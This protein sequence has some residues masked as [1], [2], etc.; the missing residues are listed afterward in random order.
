M[1]KAAAAERF[2]PERGHSLAV[3]V[4]QRIRASRLER[5]LSLAQVG[6]DDLSRSFLSL[7]EL[8]HSR[9]SLRALAIVAERLDLP[10]S[11]FLQGAS[12]S[13]AEIAEL[14][15]DRAEIALGQQQPEQALHT[16]EL[17]EVPDSLR[18]RS[19]LVRGRALTDAGRP[20]DAVPELR[21]ALG[22]AEKRDDAFLHAH[23]LYHLG[24]ALY[25]AGNFDEAAVYL[26]RALREAVETIDDSIL[27]GKAT[28]LLGHILFVEDDMDGALEQYARARELFDSFGDLD[29]LGSVYSGLSLT[30]EHK[31]DMPN[32]LRYAKLSLRTFDAKQDVRRAAGELNNLAMKYKELDDISNAL[33]CAREAVQRAGEVKA[34]DV[35]AIAHG[36]LASIHLQREEIQEA[37]VEAELADRLAAD[38]Y[39]RAHVSAWTVLAEIAERRGDQARA[40]T[41]YR[42]VLDVLKPT[43][44]H[45]A[46]ARAALAYSL[47]L[48]RRGQTDDALEYALEAAQAKA[49]SATTGHARAAV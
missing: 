3:D 44:Q 49:A 42:Q 30:Y 46:Y 15:L 17:V 23:V 16:L 6:G 10:M 11:Y 38:T 26:H 39:E 28:V 2:G 36:T 9:I 1:I 32:A 24:A 4:G 18:A 37:T 7:V 19:L 33:E 22:L 8:G 14:A 21:T 12:V 5:G 41:L 40:D 25:N 20:R 34:Q 35:E 27:T 43:A 31:G 48:R 45:E 13:S 29:A 47:L